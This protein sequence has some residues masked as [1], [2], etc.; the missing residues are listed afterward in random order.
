MPQPAIQ[1]HGVS[2]DDAEKRQVDEILAGLLAPAKRIDS[3]FFYDEYGSQLFEQITELPEYYPTRTEVGL[4]RDN[5]DAITDALGRGELLIEPGAGNCSKVRWLLPAL[6]P[7]CYVP[8]D[9]SGD[10]LIASARTLQQEFP[11][12]RILPVVGDMG[13]MLTLPP[14]YDGLRRGVF[15]P[16]S[17]IGNYE[18]VEAVEFLRRMQSM[19]G[20]DGSVLIGVDLQKEPAVLN[21]AYNDSAGVTARFNLNIL[22]H[23]NRLTDADFDLRRFRHVAFYNEIAGRIEMHV[24]SL[25]AQQVTVAG[26]AI[27]L[28]EGER[29]LTE[30]SYKYTRENF[31]ELAAQAGLRADAYWSDDQGLFSL[32]HFR[33][34]GQGYD[35]G[36]V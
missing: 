15:Y 24:E 8:I 33:V 34:S 23:V 12:I 5:C 28:Q 27:S 4:L 11:G 22:T 30:Y 14:E 18:P 17:T 9:I 26:V 1:N 2:P 10:F 6:C 32:Q 29:I 13:A 7:A 36:P 16:G 31:A 19:I 21:A 3:R 35:R 25:C 20:S